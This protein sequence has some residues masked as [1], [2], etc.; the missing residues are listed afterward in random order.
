ME[1]LYAVLIHI[2]TYYKNSKES[3]PI[4]FFWSA[5][6]QKE[7]SKKT[8][9]SEEIQFATNIKPPKIS[10]LASHLHDFV[11]FHCTH[12]SIIYL[13]LNFKFMLNKEIC[14]MTS[15]ICKL[16]LLKHIKLYCNH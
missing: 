9:S 2:C 12:S 6:V 16:F 5:D 7:D 1:F 8:Y 10:T 3:Q 15:S 13:T 14:E 4:D 11:P